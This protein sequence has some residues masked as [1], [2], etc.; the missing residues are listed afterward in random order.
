MV[1]SSCVHYVEM[2]LELVTQELPRPQLVMRVVDGLHGIH[3][4]AMSSWLAHLHDVSKI[5][6]PSC[7]GQ[8]GIFAAQIQ[9]IYHH[10]LTLCGNNVS[11]A[12]QIVPA[13]SDARLIAFAQCPPLHAMA[14]SIWEV[15]C[16][17]VS[18]A[19]C[20]RGPLERL[21][22]VADHTSSIQRNPRRIS[23]L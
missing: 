17:N 19:T 5:S 23:S 11:A 10:A 20:T 1:A 7:L 14:G 4:Y 21:V 9:N 13:A 6:G 22:T 12:Q 16:L 15:Q 3:D 2:S 8:Q 18:H